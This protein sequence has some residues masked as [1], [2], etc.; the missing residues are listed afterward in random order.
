MHKWQEIT[1]TLVYIKGVIKYSEIIN[2]PVYI[3]YEL[4]IQK[5]QLIL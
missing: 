1:K 5:V 4:A 3:S 2:D